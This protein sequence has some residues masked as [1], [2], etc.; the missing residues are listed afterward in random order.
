MQRKVI[1]IRL[2]DDSLDVLMETMQM[3]IVA[4]QRMSVT[5]DWNVGE[6]N[7]ESGESVGPILPSSV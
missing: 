2:S 3:H 7:T 4:A 5:P 6:W 1:V